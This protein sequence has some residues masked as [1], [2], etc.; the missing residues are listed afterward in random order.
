MPHHLLGG[1]H[2]QPLQNVAQLV[3]LEGGKLK[4]EE[5]TGT[6]AAPP[7]PVLVDERAIAEAARRGLA[8]LWH[9]QSSD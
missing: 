3:L 5:L 2:I 6:G 8:N 9:R 4:L 7:D 1:R